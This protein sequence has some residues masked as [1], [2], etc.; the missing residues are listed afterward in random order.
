M[1]KDNINTVE[2]KSDGVQ[3]FNFKTIQIKNGLTVEPNER[4]K[5]LDKVNEILNKI[6]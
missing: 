5:K 6:R 4:K 1:R 2:L 3:F